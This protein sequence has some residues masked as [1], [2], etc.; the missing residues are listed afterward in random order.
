MLHHV[1]IL[2]DNGTDTFAHL[3][4]AVY[5]NKFSVSNWNLLFLYS[6]T[7]PLIARTLGH[8]YVLAIMNRDSSVN[9]NFCVN[10]NFHLSEVNS[11]R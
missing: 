7:N 3:S 8:F 6:Q 2:S 4:F 10:I 1:G 5:I 9:I 11:Q